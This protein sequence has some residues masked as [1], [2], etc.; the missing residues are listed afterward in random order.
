MFELQSG[1]KRSVSVHL[2]TQSVTGSFAPPNILLAF[3][4]RFGRIEECGKALFESPLQPALEGNYIHPS[5][6]PLAS[7]LGLRCTEGPQ[8]TSQ[9][10]LSAHIRALSTVSHTSR[11]LRRA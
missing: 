3:S 2:F 6:F 5:G 4:L 8:G 7:G 1:V 10:P 9:A 11:A